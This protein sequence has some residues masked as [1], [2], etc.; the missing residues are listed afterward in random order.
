M[1]VNIQ[2]VKELLEVFYND[3]EG[4]SLLDR[5]PDEIQKF[6]TEQFELQTINGNQYLLP[7]NISALNDAFAGCSNRYKFKPNGILDIKAKWLP[8]IEAVRA[9]HPA[10]K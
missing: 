9:E 7:P 3:D 2:N 10:K 5:Y 6:V 4:P 8:T 1:P